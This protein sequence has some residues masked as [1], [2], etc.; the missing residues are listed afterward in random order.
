MAIEVERKYEVPEDFHL[1]DLTDVDGVASVGDPDVLDL[2]ALYYDSHDLRLAMSKATLRRRT[3]GHDAGWHLKRPAGRGSE[4]GDRSELQEALT[5]DPPADLLSQVADVL[6]DAPLVPVARVRNHRR[7]R[8]VRDAGGAV[9]ALIAEDDVSSKRLIGWRHRQSWRELEVELVNGDREILDKIQSKLYAAGAHTSP[10]AS[11]FAR[12]YG[13]VDGGRVL[14]TYLGGQVA[15]FDENAGGARD[16]DADAVHDAR[17]A[18]RRIRST[19]KAFGTLLPPEQDALSDE[20]RWLSGLL[21]AVRDGDVLIAHFTAVIERDGGATDHDESNPAV[22]PAAAAIRERLVAA[23]ADDR[24]AL[25]AALDSDRFARLRD[26]LAS[27]PEHA[28]TAGCSTPTLLL[29]ARRAVRR[30]GRHLHSAT[31]IPFG[32]PSDRDTALHDARKAY[33][34]A[35]YAVELVRPLAGRHAKRLAKRLVALQDALG[36]HQ[37]GTVAAGIVRRYAEKAHR[38]GHDT[39][40]YGLLYARTRAG[41]EAALADLPHLLRRAGKSRVQL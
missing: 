27:L 36:V 30:A 14:A 4:P 40:A 28:A 6:G 19:M 34:R 15:A 39:F 38:D 10:S 18:L 22:A 7:E 29:T 12:A 35:R 33:K 31:S 13:E 17:V 1:P 24:T 20:L 21:G 32:N 11:K 5:D 16:G 3:G 41:A 2:D 9:L 25:E 26:L 8:A 23:Q 37:D